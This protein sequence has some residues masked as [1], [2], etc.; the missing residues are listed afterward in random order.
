M[1]VVPTPP[2]AAARARCVRA[3]ELDQ[4]SRAGGVVVRARAGACV[5]A[6]RHH[7][8]GLVRAARRDRDEVD[9]LPPAEPWNRLLEAVLAH[10]EAVR[11][12]AARAPRCA[13][14]RAPGDPGR[15]V[16]MQDGQV[17]GELTRGGAV[18]HGR[19][20]RRRKRA[21]PR[22]RER[23]HEQREGHQ[24]PGATVEPPVDWP[25]ERAGPR[26]PPFGWGRERRH[27]R[28]IVGRVQAIHAVSEADARLLNHSPRR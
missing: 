8:D 19:Q 26:A 9:E 17:V 16:R 24:E 15:P 10:A 6:V 25:G 13:A 1:L 7:D 4:R 12:R 27:R 28:A 3:G 5:V 14:S 22:H 2:S 11:L 23:R 20:R 21:G 18:E